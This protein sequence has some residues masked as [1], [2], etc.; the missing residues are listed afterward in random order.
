MVWE[1]PITAVHGAVEDAA[2]SCTAGHS[3]LSVVKH[4]LIQ[5]LLST[6]VSSGTVTESLSV[7]TKS[8]RCP[9]PPERSRE[10]K[11]A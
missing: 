4:G 11:S 10:S 7:V 9:L 1:T 6:D 2:A 8:S 5:T 3:P